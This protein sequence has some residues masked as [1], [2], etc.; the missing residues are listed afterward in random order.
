VGAQRQLDIRLL[1]HT[2]LLLLLLLLLQMMLPME[3]FV[4]CSSAQCQ[5]DMWQLTHTLL[6]LVLLLQML[7]NDLFV[8]WVRNATLTHGN[9]HTRCCCCCCR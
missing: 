6:L 1:T 7:P 8:E 4:E 3:S 2:L 5:I 9:S